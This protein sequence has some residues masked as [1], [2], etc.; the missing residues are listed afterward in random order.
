MTIIR[1]FAP[2]IALLAV[3]AVGAVGAASAAPAPAS[4]DSAAAARVRAHVEFLADDLLEGRG[5]GT[6][7]HE[8]AAAYVV[9]QFRALGLQPAGENGGWYQ[10]VPFRRATLAPGKSSVT[11]L[12]NG[13]PVALPAEALTV[14]P[15]VTEKTLK[16]DAGLLFVGYGLADRRYGFD[17]YAGL[18]ARGKILVMFRGVPKGLPSDIAAHLAGSKDKI[19]ASRGAVGL[20]EISPRPRSTANRNGASARGASTVDWV[21]V[22]SAEAV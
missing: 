20:I 5:T 7:G 12:D 8:I 16:L 10:W 15:S 9:S 6:R 3:G 18:D 21:D 22:V 11:L 2:A 14:S 13:K 1:I 4:A 19:A 17:D